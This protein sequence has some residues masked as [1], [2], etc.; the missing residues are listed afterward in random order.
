ME[1]HVNTQEANRQNK[2]CKYYTRSTVASLTSETKSER[3]GVRRI[4]S[5]PVVGLPLSP[6]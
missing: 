1:A 5:I 6:T 3:E 4:Y 2:V